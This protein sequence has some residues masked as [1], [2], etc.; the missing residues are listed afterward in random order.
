[1]IFKIDPVIELICIAES[2]FRNEV[3]TG[4][5]DLTLEMKFYEAPPNYALH[6][7]LLRSDGAQGFI[8]YSRPVPG[9]W[10]VG[11]YFSN[12]AM[13]IKQPLER[14]PRHLLRLCWVPTQRDVMWALNSQFSMDYF[15]PAMME[16]AA[17]SKG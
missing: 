15:R 9:E 12:R 5:K 10:E 2:L 3:G 7:H 11:P 4:P 1:M 17:L 14:D 13:E 6:L 8:A 16:L